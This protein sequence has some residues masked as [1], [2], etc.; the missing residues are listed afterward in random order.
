VTA[1]VQ[2]QG[3]EK[4]FPV[5][6]GL[7]RRAVGTIRAVDGVDFEIQAGETLGLVGESGSGKSTTGRALLRLV[8]PSF[9]RVL[10]A[11]EDMARLDA[12]GLRSARRHMQM[13]FQ[14]A[15]LNPRLGVGAAI[16]EPLDIHGEGPRSERE[17]RVREL[18]GLVGLPVE[19]AGRRPYELSGGQRQRVGIARALATSPRFV[20]A[21]EPI[22]SLDV[23]VQAQV[24]NLLLDLKKR[25]GLTYLLIAHDLTM[26]RHVSDRVAVM[27]LGRIVETASRAALFQ[28]PLHPY[29]Q[30]LLAAVPVPDPDRERRRPPRA[31]PGEPPSPAHPPSGCRFHT[32]CPIATDLCRVRDPEPRNL[33]PSEAPHVV[34]CHHAT[35]PSPL[36]P[37]DS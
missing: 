12:R 37:G 4:H 35:A 1:L 18:L 3:L 34:A 17:A 6:R 21:D 33:G 28:D 22:S 5:R 32:R 26:V 23:S 10:F 20:V 36:P 27:Y 15:A 9:G 14:N 2:V 13:V 8:E 31:L 19:I 24:V 16:R 25:L 7:L 29:T 30:A 11:G